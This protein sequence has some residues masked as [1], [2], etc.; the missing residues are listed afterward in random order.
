MH[1]RTASPS[2]R[3]PA[4]AC[5]ACGFELCPLELSVSTPFARDGRAPQVQ[6]VR[7]DIAELSERVKSLE[8][9]RV[10]ADAASAELNAAISMKRNETERERKRKERLE[11]DLKE[12]K[13]TVETRHTD[14]KAR[15][16]RVVLLPTLEGGG[17]V[18]AT[19]VRGKRR[20]GD[21]LAN[22]C[23]RGI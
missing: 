9:E 16:A 19:E 20:E 4:I 2:M 21:W 15:Q 7:A 5:V 12:L 1:S 11:R 10:Q 22:A 6:A 18:A 14:I 3:P 8:G 17:Q 13:T 23:A